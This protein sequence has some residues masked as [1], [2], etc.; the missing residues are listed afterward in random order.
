MTIS[1]HRTN[2][3]RGFARMKSIAGDAEETYV[4][5]NNHNLG[6]STVNALQLKAA[7]GFPG[8]G[9]DRRR[10]DFHSFREGL[11]LRTATSG[12]ARLLYKRVHTNFSDCARRDD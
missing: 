12:G 6:K 1:I 8:V 9:G 10:P 5:T 4:V 3:S 2:W 11:S 7:A